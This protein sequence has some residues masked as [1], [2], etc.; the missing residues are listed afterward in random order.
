MKIKFSDDMD[1]TILMAKDSMS[2]SCCLAN[3]SW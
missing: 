1:S 2:F 3:S